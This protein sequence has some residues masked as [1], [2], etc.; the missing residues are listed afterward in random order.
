MDDPLTLL[1]RA[2]AQEM[3]AAFKLDRLGRLQ[4]LADW[5]ASFPARRFSRQILR[6]DDLVAQHGLAA[7]GRYI[8]DDFTSSICIEGQW[9]VPLRGP[10]LAVANHPGMVDVLAVC[11]ALERRRDLK[12][13]AA[14]REVL[15]LIPNFRNRLL[16]VNPRTG[17]RSGLLRDATS[18]LRQGGALLTFPAGTIEPDPSLRAVEPLAGWSDSSEL[19]VR[20][21]P[22]TLVLPIAVSG[23]ISRTAQQHR[24]AKRFADQKEREWA[25]A[26]LQVLC[27]RL[28]D[29]QTRVMIGE[30]ISSGHLTLR[31]AIHAAMASL[32]AC[33]N[34]RHT[35]GNE[36]YPELAAV[37]SVS[38]CPSAEQLPAMGGIADVHGSMERCVRER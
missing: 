17:G 29:T 34:I 21:V 1:T 7:A 37:R 33:I 38:L 11:V 12:I 23:V 3:L 36:A 4:P 5:L 30:P 13:I 22:E 6:F 15:R 16:F 9:H 2:N 10:L 35:V 31:A 26:T 27:R 28:R 19:F 14:E 18:H 24:I 25:A 8:L 32:L 20:L